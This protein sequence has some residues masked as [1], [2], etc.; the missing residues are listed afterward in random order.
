MTSR[1]FLLCSETA[2]C[3]SLCRVFSLRTANAVVVDTAAAGTVV[4]ETV[5]AGTVVVGTV[6]IAFAVVVVVRSFSS[7]STIRP[8]SDS[9][10]RSPFLDLRL[11]LMLDQRPDHRL[12]CC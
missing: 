5:A 11:H 3:E 6:R 9:F 8:S 12:D 10:V 1:P 2:S 7:S 4:V